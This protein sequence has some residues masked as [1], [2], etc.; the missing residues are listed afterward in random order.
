MTNI[1][2]K[3][4]LES[5][6]Y[7]NIV[8]FLNDRSIII[9][10]RDKSGVMKRTF[11]H[12]SDPL[13]KSIAFSDFPYIIAELPTMDYSKVSVNGKVKNITWSMNLTVRTARDGSGQGTSAVGKTDILSIGDDLNDLFNTDTY[14]QQLALLRMFFT[15]LTKENTDTLSIDQKLIYEASYTVEFQERIVVSL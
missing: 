14:K 13:A 9:D 12:D 6:A 7:D 3:S 8:S 2:T 10:P 11:V 15:K 5:N 4:T 1:I